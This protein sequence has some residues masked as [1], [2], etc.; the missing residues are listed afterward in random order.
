MTLKT[1][2]FAATLTAGVSTFAA[3]DDATRD[4]FQTITRTDA[5]TGTPIQPVKLAANEAAVFEVK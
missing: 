5:L 3:P 1:L 2:L 4:I